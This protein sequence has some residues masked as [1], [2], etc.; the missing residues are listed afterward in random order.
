MTVWMSDP[1]AR[2]VL[3]TN[4]QGNNR[5]RRNGR[6]KDDFTEFDVEKKEGFESEYLNEDEE[7]EY[8]SAIGTYK[9]MV[10]S[11]AV[12]EKVFEDEISPSRRS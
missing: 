2:K 12:V 1:G 10:P 9:R 6:R 5:G 3:E 8:A 4:E 11:T 7:K